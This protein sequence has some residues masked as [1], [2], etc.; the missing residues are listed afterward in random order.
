V[1]RRLGGI[2]VVRLALFSLILVGLALAAIRSAA[3]QPAGPT[4]S[5]FDQTVSEGDAE[6]AFVL[7]CDN[8]T[9]L[10][11]VITWATSDGTATAPD[12]YQGATEE[13]VVVPGPSEQELFVG[14]TNDA[15]PEPDETFLITLS[16]ADGVVV[17]DRPQ[18]T[19]T[20]RDDDSQQTGPC[21]TLSETATSFSAPFSTASRREFAGP[22][23]RIELRNCGS[24]IVG[25]EARGT[26]ATGAGATWELI[27]ASSAGPI[28]SLCELGLDL[29]RA[30][31]SV[32]LSDGGGI[33]TPLTET[34]TPLLD[35]DSSTSP[36]EKLLTLDPAA[37][38]EMSIDVEMPCQGS[39]GLGQPMSMDVVLAAVP[40]P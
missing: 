20:I 19:G 39:A 26:D 1:G 32:W 25:I 17:F 9:P 18:A 23:D 13:R 29:F 5:V 33:G 16:D 15:D 6:A 3:A 30:V 14:V 36:T 37:E 28:D 12:D 24:S 27:N 11:E 7:D 35:R 31:L 21:I 8:P 4:C 2:L 38:R 34:P 10:N 40:A 22:G